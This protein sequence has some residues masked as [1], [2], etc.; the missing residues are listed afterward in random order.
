M[1]ARVTGVVKFFDDEKGYGFLRVDGE[2]QDVFVHHKNIL[3]PGRR[4]LEMGQAVTCEV[5]KTDK[6]MSAQNVAMTGPE[7]FCPTCG[8]HLSEE[9]RRA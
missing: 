7:T 4:K 3:M 6:G 2:E 9:S 8:H 1:T 5:I